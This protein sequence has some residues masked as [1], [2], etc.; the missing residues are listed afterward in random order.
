MIILRSKGLPNM[1][2]LKGAGVRRKG[3]GGGSGDAAAAAA[4]DLHGLG[5]PAGVLVLVVGAG[6]PGG[7]VGGMRGSTG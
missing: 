4:E 3:G 1:S 5:L 6:V 2:P 7:R